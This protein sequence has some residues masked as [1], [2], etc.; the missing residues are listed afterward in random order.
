MKDERK[1]IKIAKQYVFKPD[2]VRL[3]NRMQIRKG[4][5]NCL[6]LLIPDDKIIAKALNIISFDQE[7]QFFKED[8]DKIDLL[9]EELQYALKEII[10]KSL[11]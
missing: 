9:I 3:L 6:V 2:H 8:S 11:F 7:G 5:N 10:N 4:E 1:R